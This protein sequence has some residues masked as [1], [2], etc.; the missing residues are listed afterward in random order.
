MSETAHQLRVAALVDY[1]R[2][3]GKLHSTAEV[4]TWLNLARNRIGLEQAYRADIDARN[5]LN[6]DPTTDQ[7]V[8]AAK[9]QDAAGDHVRAS[10]WSADD[11]L[12]RVMTFA[13]EVTTKSSNLTFQSKK[14]S[15]K[16][17]ANIDLMRFARDSAALGQQAVALRIEIERI[18]ASR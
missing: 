10:D 12:A 17:P 13:R 1:Y 11:D 16:H 14:V 3:G 15:D 8:P 5:E 4:R 2:Q 6:R 7:V 18:R 9:V